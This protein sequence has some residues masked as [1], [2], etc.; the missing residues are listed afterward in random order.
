MRM[1]YENLT[2]FFVY[3]FDEY[4]CYPLVI[5]HPDFFASV[6]RSMGVQCKKRRV[7][8]D[9]VFSGKELI[10]YYSRYRCNSYRWKDATV[11]YLL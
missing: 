11:L 8:R 6:C 1:F 9:L 4:D 3:Y 10:N 7:E 2:E 5:S